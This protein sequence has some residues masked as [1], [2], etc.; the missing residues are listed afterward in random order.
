ML[1]KFLYSGGHWCDSY[2]FVRLHQP[3]ALYGVNSKVLGDARDRLE[4]DNLS[5]G[6][7]LQAYYREVLQSLEA[8]GV[9]FL[10]KYEYELGRNDGAHVVTSLL[11]P[12]KQYKVEVAKKLVDG[13]YIGVTIPSTHPPK[14][15]FDKEKT[16]VVPVN[17]L[18]N[19]SRSYEVYTVVGAGKTG[20][21]ACL[22]LIDNDVDPDR[23]H[24]V[25]P[26]DSWMFIR[27]GFTEG[28]I[29]R[30]FGQSL[31]AFDEAESLEHL[32]H[33]LEDGGQLTRLDKTREPTMW[34]CATV[35]DDEMVKLRSIKNI[36]RKGR[37]KE[38]TPQGIVF[39]EGT[40]PIEQDT[41][42]V[43]CTSDG[44]GKSNSGRKWKSFAI[45]C[46]F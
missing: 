43:D 34:R 36:I 5:S 35:S 29:I 24:W 20:I 9:K 26:N 42:F 3:A 23:I 33:L 16:T 30:N 39:Q 28:T 4:V 6:V 11:D 40:V 2:S 25:M 18:V 45:F 12:A 19:L 14:Y 21:D 7:E 27:A 32:F 17:S 1:N 22:W 37:I 41:I 38:I 8:K 13:A 31:S 10:A 46:D 15:A 44:L